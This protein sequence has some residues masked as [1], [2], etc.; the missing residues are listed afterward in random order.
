MNVWPPFMGPMRKVQVQWVSNT[1]YVRSFFALCGM[2]ENFVDIC[3]QWVLARKC[4]CNACLRTYVWP[5]TEHLNW[6]NGYKGTDRLCL[7]REERA[8]AR[9]Q[10]QQER[11]RS[12]QTEVRQASLDR[13][14]VHGE[15]SSVCRSIGMELDSEG[16][17]VSTCSEH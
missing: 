1:T 7:E 15:E 13:R 9:H 16:S 6:T 17:I 3:I 12:E 8:T 10:R 5:Y 11:R 2:T 14:C 4:V